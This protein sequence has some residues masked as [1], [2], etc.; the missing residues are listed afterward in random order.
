MLRCYVSIKLSANYLILPQIIITGLPATAPQQ[1]EGKN[2]YFDVPESRTVAT[3]QPFVLPESFISGKS[4][5]YFGNHFN[6]YFHCLC[7]MYYV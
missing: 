1:K 4:S 5:D 2:N 6:V 3:A 7:P